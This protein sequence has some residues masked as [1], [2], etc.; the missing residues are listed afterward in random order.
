MYKIR[1][2][3]IG[4]GRIA[5]RHAVHI[6]T[7][8]TLVAV[9]DSNEAK[10][11]TL[12]EKYSADSFFAIEDL[13]AAK[14]EID[15]VVICTPN[16]LHAQHAIL[17]LNK[18][19][20]VLV[21]KPMAL[22]TSDCIDMMAAAVKAGKQLFTVVQNRF[23]PPVTAVKHALEHQAFGKISSIQLTCFWNRT[24]DYYKDSWKGT[25]VMDGGILFTQ[26]SHF[27]DLLYW[28]FGDVKK[29]TAITKNADH[30]DN[31]EFE[32]CGVAILEF[33]NGIIGTI[34]FSVN[35]FA[36]NREGSLSILGEK[37][38]VKIGG[39]YLNT[40][41]YQ[42]FDNYHLTKITETGEAND[43]GTYKGSMSNHDKVYA[44]LVDTLQNGA[45]FYANTFEGL[46]T[47]ELIER[48]YRA[49]KEESIK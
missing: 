43:Y 36:K 49:A 4:C 3:I 17:A 24:N 26:F 48:I 7:Y 25:K 1:F 18:G 12:A 2:A 35:S 46:K 42:K 6:H 40:I 31:I 39:E 44:N 22:S 38:T 19:F 27:I 16:G 29:I 11:N 5:E 21:E 33:E 45:Q 32:D 41:E 14:R 30:S 20:H 10:A 15:V 8:G 47:V 9:C 13:L 28:F 34:N 37:G 23:N